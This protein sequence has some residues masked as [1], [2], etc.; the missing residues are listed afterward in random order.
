MV[1]IRKRTIQTERPPLVGEVS[2]TF[3]DRG[4]RVVRAMNPHGRII[5]F[6]DR[7]SYY[8]FQVAPKLYS[9]GW[10]DPVADPEILRKS[11]R[12]GNQTQ[13]LWIYSQELWPQRRPTTAT[14]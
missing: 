9:W 1:L 2:G 12:A 5:V 7:S 14:F 3:A 11:G 8:F 4:C 13:D 10:V 6:L